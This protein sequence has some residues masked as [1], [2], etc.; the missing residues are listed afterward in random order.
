MKKPTP[1]TVTARAQVV[2]LNNQSIETSTSFIVHPSNL[3]VGTNTA[4]TCT[5]LYVV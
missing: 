4:G 2:D 1:I 5:C 3:Y